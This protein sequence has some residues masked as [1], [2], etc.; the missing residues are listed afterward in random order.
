MPC[1]AGGFILRRIPKLGMPYMGA[2]RKLSKPLVDFMLKENP[3]AKYFYDLFG[4]GG[5][6]SFEAIQRP[7]IKQ[8]FYNEF[9]TGVV[10]L[11]KDVLK[12]GIDEK[13]YKWIDRETF[14]ENKNGDDWLGG[15]CKVCWSFGNNQR[16]YIFSKEIEEDKRLLHEI[17]VNNCK[18]SLKIFNKKF[19]TNLELENKKSLFDEET[20]TQKRLRVMGI[21]KQENKRFDL[22]QLERLQQ[23]QRLEQFSISNLSYLDVEI[24]TSINETI[25]YLDPPYE[26]TA[27]YEKSICHKELYEYIKKS[28][29]KIYIS[30]YESHLDCVLELEHRSTL[31]ATKN[32]KK[33]IEK[34]FTNRS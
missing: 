18:K 5:S 14:N 11:L 22:Q 6:M 34:L 15:F 10:E 24:K 2:K 25:I 29:Y 9:N 20:I 13:Y 26:N 19:K 21:L 1:R 8:V 12:N 17:V 7:Q 27:G 23:L 4:G 31:S 30:S 32:D 16:N 3:N 28:P 33:V